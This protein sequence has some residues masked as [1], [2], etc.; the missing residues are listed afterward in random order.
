M[1][2]LTAQEFVNYLQLVI[3]KEG[4]FPIVFTNCDYEGQSEFTTIEGGQ[5][6]IYTCVENGNK[7]INI[8]LGY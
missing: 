7:V 5:Q 6:G 3:N 8:D 2:K 4:D 1:N